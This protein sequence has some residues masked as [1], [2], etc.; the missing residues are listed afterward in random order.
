MEVV[1]FPLKAYSDHCLQFSWNWGCS[2]GNHYHHHHPSSTSSTYVDCVYHQVTLVSLPRNHIRVYLSAYL[3]WFFWESQSSDKSSQRIS[4]SGWWGFA[5]YD[6]F[7]R[8]KFTSTKSDPECVFRKAYISRIR[9]NDPV[10]WI[11]HPAL[12]KGFPAQFLTSPPGAG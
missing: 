10:H 3:S 12:P 5:E 11:W 7:A 4:C 8:L 1:M 6:T 2:P 9:T